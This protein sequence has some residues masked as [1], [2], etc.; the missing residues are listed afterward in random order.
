MLPLHLTRLFGVLAHVDAGKTTLS[1]RLLYFSGRIRR[2]GDVHHGDTTLDSSAEERRH[3]ITISAAA[4]TTRW[5]VGDEPVHQLSLIDTPGHVDFAVEVERALTVLDGAVVVLDAANGVEPQTEAVWRQADEHG[6]PRVVFVNKLD[7]VGASLPRCLEQLRDTLGVD[8]VP[9]QQLLPDGGLVDVIH[10]EALSFDERGTLTRRPFPAPAERAALVERLAEHDDG[11]AERFLHGL[12]P[13]NDEVHAALRRLTL[14]RVVVPVLCGSALKHRGI[15]P[16]LDAVVRYL[17]S[18]LERTLGQGLKAQVDAPSCAFVFKTEVDAHLGALCWVRVFQGAIDAGDVLRVAG[19]KKTERVTRLLSLHGAGLEP[20]DRAVPG[21]VAVLVGFKS[22]KTGDTLCGGALDVQLD[23]LR[24]AEP[25]VQ[26]AVEAES[27]EAH[28][29]LGEALRRAC[30]VDPSLRVRVDD[31][32]GQTLLCGV[33]ELHLAMWLERLERTERL[34]LKVSPPQ[35]ARRVTPASAVAVTYRHVQQRGGPGQFAVVSVALAP[36]P[37]GVGVQFT[38]ETTGGV[39][40]APF[41]A[42]VED[43]VRAGLSCGGP[44][45]EPVVD[46]AVRLV[47][48]QTHPKD[49]SAAAFEAAGTFAVRAALGQAGLVRLVPMASV[50]VHVPDTFTGGVVG[51]LS[52]RGGQVRGLEVA[53]GRARVDATLALEATFG[54]VTALRSKSEGR[55][56]VS[57]HP[58]GYERG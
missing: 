58:A 51:E 26:L 41:V 27:R 53:R 52:A 14:S 25:L 33:G 12:R 29:K 2:M 32:T 10:E 4:T 36:L 48:G 38:D 37:R 55:A 40:P 6:V 21:T 28:A 8:A 44:S 49:S 9:L 18:P 43:G 11:M 57:V 54:L 3:G 1:E 46:V 13:T 23:G 15:Q 50:Q 35:V 47:D 31:E 30:F 42:A 56:Q 22:A 39:V 34:T 45:G 19:Q 16:V 17:P 7:A 5:R 24:V 20:L